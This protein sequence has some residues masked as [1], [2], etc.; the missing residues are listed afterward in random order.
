MAN[1]EE[2]RRFNILTGGEPGLLVNGGWNMGGGGGAPNRPTPG[3]D[4]G[5]PPKPKPQP[6]PK[7]NMTIAHH[8]GHFGDGGGPDLMKQIMS[9]P[10][11]DESDYE[12]ILGPDYEN[13]IQQ[14]QQQSLLIS[15]G[16]FTGGG[17]MTNDGF[18]VNAAGETFR[19]NRDGSFDYLG[20][21][22]EDRFGPLIP[23][24]AP[25]RA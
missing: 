22:T 17:W 8:G 14:Y 2:E 13:K 25:D 4:K 1:L 12:R 15:G 6:A 3:W 18:G 11:L 19:Q 24:G 5:W 10:T 16:P 9:D 21:Y 7:P 20:P 23:S